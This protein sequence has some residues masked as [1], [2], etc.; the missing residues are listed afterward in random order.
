VFF[1]LGDKAIYK[2]GASETA[3]NRLCGNSLIM[4][5]AIKWY[6]ARGFAL[7]HFG[8]SSIANE[9]L[10]QFKLSFGTEEYKIDYFKYDFRKEAF[11]AERDKVFGWF[12]GIFRLMPIPLSRMLGILMYRHLS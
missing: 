9:G 8:R 4:W 10:R 1:H 6:S 5:E 2:F 3:F 7:L 11:V 12:N